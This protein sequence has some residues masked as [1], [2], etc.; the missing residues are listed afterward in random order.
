V[1]FPAMTDDFACRSWCIKYEL[2]S[3]SASPFSSACFWHAEHAGRQEQVLLRGKT[4]N[5]PHCRRSH[6]N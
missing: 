4:A 5:V 6:E 1:S 2:L 3:V